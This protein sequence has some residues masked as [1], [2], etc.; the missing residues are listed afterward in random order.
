MANV[1]EQVVPDLYR[2][3]C[4][5]NG[6]WVS[7]Q[8]RRVLEV[9]NPA[10]G[11]VIGEIPNL[12]P[13]DV[14][15][16]IDAASAAFRTW[17][18]TTAAERADV[19]DRWYREILACKRE[20]ATVLMLE[21]G[22]PL[23]EALGEIQISADYVR[24]FAEEARRVAGEVIA[25]PWPGQQLLV[26]KQPVGVCAAITP[27][28]FPSS[29]VTRKLAP[30]LAAGCTVVLKPAETTPFSALA[31]GVLAE[32]AGVPAGVINIV[33]GDAAPIGETLCTDPV[34]RKISFTGSTHVGRLIAA[35]CAPTIKRLSL[36]LGGNAP[37][38]VFEDADIEAAVQGLMIS[39]F[40]N[41]GQTCVCANRVYVHSGI[42]DAFA[43]AL[44]QAVDKL[45]VGNGHVEGV[46]QGPLINDRALSKVEEY[47]QD[48]LDHGG[49]ILRG[50][51]PHSAGGTFYEPTI[52]TNVSRRAR[53]AREEIFGPVAPL[54]RFESEAELLE[55]VND[56]EFGLAAYV[57][58]QSQPRMLRMMES[59]ECGMVAINSGLMT[60]VSA[61]FGGVKQ[62][63][64]GREGGRQ[65]IDE[66]LDE[67][68]I[69]IAP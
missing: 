59:I 10:D 30:A 49:T 53:M 18:K 15:A 35:Q 26:L 16:A 56:T 66:Y 22:K 13:A 14:K 67:K 17:R 1:L 33:T 57:Y 50:G 40:R 4:W 3:Q 21:Q 69:C 36:E 28:N 51:R 42:Y 11:S 25:S 65:G 54:Y 63:G 27:W 23:A 31:L 47:V 61:P 46:T 24:W 32:R 43:Q 9:T 29:M 68:Y 12:G 6:E 44:A 37:F 58:T 39:K 48:A 5:I 41:T 19:L 52:I 45:I 8:R 7:E 55:M 62:S 64:L 60:T 34:V 2:D 38:I 20:L